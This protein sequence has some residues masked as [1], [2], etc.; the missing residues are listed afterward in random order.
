MILA[1]GRGER[2][3]PLTDH[4]PKVLAPVGGEPL[5]VHQIRWLVAAGITEIVVNLHH[6]GD[7]IR[8]VVGDGGAYGARVRYSEEPLLLETGGGVVRALPLLGTAPILLL[9]G[10]IYTDFPF[11]RMA[12]RL[13]DH[14]GAHLLLTPRPPFREHGDFEMTDGW[15][16]GR[17]ETFVY[18]GIAVLDPGVLAG[19]SPTPFSL[20]DVYFDLL[21]RGA[22]SAQVWRGYWHDIGT[23]ANLAAVDTHHRAL[24]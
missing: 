4:L 14:A 13:T 23:A 17:G 3:R 11:D 7:Q 24:G 19:R 16:T 8:S 1:A 20:R 12:P 15:I 10:D 2:L 21:A 9:N 5:I 6:L 18:C 22:L